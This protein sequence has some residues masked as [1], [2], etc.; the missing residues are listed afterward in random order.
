MV[1]LTSD[2]HLMHRNIPKYRP[3]FS[4][5]EEHDEYMFSKLEQLNKRDLLFILGD[6]LFDGPH[7]A[8]YIE[9]LKKLPCRIRLVMGNHDSLKLLQEPWIEHRNPLASYKGFWLSHYP[10]HP[11]EMRGRN[12]NIH[13]HLHSMAVTGYNYDIGQSYK[14]PRYFNVNIEDNNYN[15]VKLETI[16]D[17][18]KKE[19]Q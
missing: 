4:T 14:D 5:M 17:Y 18:F 16:K 2:L 3:M 12:G 19:L 13:G 6:F 9:R 10:I 8:A 1:L 15:F 7:Y 11:Q